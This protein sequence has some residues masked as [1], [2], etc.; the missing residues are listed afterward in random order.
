MGDSGALA[1]AEVI[2]NNSTISILTLCTS[3]ICID[4]NLIKAKGVTAL[5]KALEG[6]KSIKKLS[7]SNNKLGDEGASIIS[8]YLEKNTSIVD[9]N[10]CI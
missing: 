9:L 10:L 7:L 8:K 3:S 5:G 4:M 1:I 2:S 6:N